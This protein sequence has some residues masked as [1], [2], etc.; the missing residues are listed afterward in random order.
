M[1][2]PKTP[3]KAKP[4][5]TEA[6]K[7]KAARAEIKELKRQLEHAI[8]LQTDFSNNLKIAQNELQETRESRDNL[9][10]V[11]ADLFLRPPLQDILT[12]YLEETTCD[13]VTINL[14]QR[15]RQRL[16]NN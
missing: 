16:S 6:Q 15:L 5:L 11:K 2:T 3:A 12:G 7:L 8:E 14:I 1:P 9:A 4:V 10:I 13:E